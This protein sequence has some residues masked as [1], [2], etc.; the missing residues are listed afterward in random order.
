[1]GGDQTAR[2]SLEEALEEGLRQRRPLLGVGARAELVDEH[3]ALRVG[4]LE[5]L[6]QPQQVGGEGGEALLQAL[7][8]ADVHEELGGEV[9]R[10][11]LGGHEEPGLGHEHREAQGLEQRGLAAHVGAGEQQ[12]A[13][14]GGELEVVGD[15]AGDEG[16]AGVGQ[17]VGARLEAGPGEPPVLGQAGGGAG[18]V[19]LDEGLEGFRQLGVVGQN[20]REL[21]EDA[22]DLGLLLQAQAGELVVE[23]HHA[24]GL[25]EDRHPGVRLVE[26]DARD[27]VL[28]AG[29]HRDH[30][31]VAPDGDEPVLDGAGVAVHEAVEPVLDA[32]AQRVERGADL[33]QARAGRV[34]HVAGLVERL[35]DPA[36]EEGVLAD[37]GRDGL[38]P[39]PDLQQLV[40]ELGGGL[41]AVRDA[42]QVEALQPPPLP[43]HGQRRA[44]VADAPQTV[45]VGHGLGHQGLLLEGLLEA[46][47]GAQAQRGLLAHEGR[48]PVGEGLLNAVKF[49]GFEGVTHKPASKRPV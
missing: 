31:A 4:V 35:P 36:A 9:E 21:E 23:R 24:G 7:L 30:V 12:D 38:E 5:H 27:L 33:A 39:L 42:Q 40:L 28:G 49:Q 22:V 44:Q 11:A 14:L 20:P 17:A 16:V 15:G 32:L 34:A 10:R 45:A 48:G 3:Q 13:V 46:G 37:A 25:E 43:G 8:V 2:A 41:E 18:E 19:E 1:M 6:L 29:L 26:H 47:L